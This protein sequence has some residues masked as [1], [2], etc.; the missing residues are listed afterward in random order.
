M[1]LLCLCTLAGAYSL[2]LS[3][4]LFSPIL[5]CMLL[6]FSFVALSRHISRPAAC[7]L[8][9]FSA[10][11]LS[12]LQQK[13]DELDPSLQGENIIFTAK[14]EDFPIADADSVRFIVHALDRTDLPRRIRLTWYQPQRIPMIGESWR[15]QARLKRPRGYS[16]P[17]GFDFEG[18]LFR[19][20]I[21]GTGYVTA[22]ARNYLIHGERPGLI[23]RIRQ[24]FVSRIN[25]NFPGDDASAVL[26]AIGVGARQGIGQEQWDLYARTGT[27]HLMAISGLHIGLAAGCAYFLCWALCA[28]FCTRNNL[29]DIATVGAILAAVAYATLSGF[30][31]PAQRAVLM[32]IAGGI[33]LLFRRRVRPA[34]LLAVSCLLVSISDPISILTPG[35]KLSFAAVAILIFVARRHTCAQCVSYG[36]PIGRGLGGLARLSQLQLALLTGLFPLTILL[37]GRFA[38]VAPAINILVLPIFSV[39]TVPLALAG[40]IFDGPLEF[41]GNQFLA[42]AQGSI[43]GI[44]WLVS[45]A[46]DLDVASSQ[47]RHLNTLFTGVAFLPLVFVVLPPGWPGRKVAFVAMV[48]VLA[49]RQPA[50]PPSCFDYHIL[51]VGQGLAVVLQTHRHALL[52]DTGPS[53]LNGSNTADLVV[54][55]FLHGL[56]I[57]RLDT[58]IISHGD[59]D[60]AG[61]AYSIVKEIDIDEILAG[62][63]L[64][65]LNRYQEPCVAGDRWRWDSID[66]SILHPRRNALWKRNNSSCVLL[67]EAADFKVLLT[68]DI[69]SPAEKLLIHRKLVSASDVVV[70]PHHGSL[71]SS[72]AAFVEITAPDLAIVSAGFENRWG[73]PRPETVTRW[74]ASGADVLIT[75]TMGAISQRVCPDG[76]SEPVRLQRLEER[77]FW[78]QAPP[79]RP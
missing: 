32:A 1:L 48:A 66:F 76:R 29:R 67:I 74:Q 25:E 5:F 12:A 71:T 69:E 70:V 58:L 55:P 51:D 60:H 17:G 26:M 45:S 15:L 52:F 75:A 49:Y 42:W 39:V 57:D 30:A 44:L 54:L 53:F 19:Q 79:R 35:F 73:F 43:T 31:V 24:R 61:G 33:L 7:F 50:P 78:Q 21:G 56:G 41:V 34:A 22:N 38:L 8:I 3:P 28:P 14:V 4:D 13:S 10:M 62:E 40:A 37:F 11:G 23:D 65:A 9:G 6:V 36:L 72:S 27:S 18:W 2:T 63:E 59:L 64:P 16:N 77:K 68:G 46:G 47:S 20:H